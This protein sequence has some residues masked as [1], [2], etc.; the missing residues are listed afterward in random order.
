MGTKTQQIY[1]SLFN[2]WEKFFCETGIDA[3]P[4]DELSEI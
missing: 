4:N 1:P 2:K 3:M